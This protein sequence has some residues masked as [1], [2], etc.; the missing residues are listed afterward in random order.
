MV[1]YS[2]ACSGDSWWGGFYPEDDPVWYNQADLRCNSSSSRNWLVWRIT[3]L[4]FLLGL[5]IVLNGKVY[6]CS[7]RRNIPLYS[8]GS[9]RD[10]E[11]RTCLHYHNISFLHYPS[12]LHF[13]GL[14]V[15]TCV[16]ADRKVSWC[17]SSARRSYWKHSR[18]TCT[19]AGN[20]VKRN[21]LF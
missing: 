5:M 15:R 17:Y 20:D 9:K 16:T 18:N 4:Y 12:H 10:I 11:R 14:T 2:I 6:S 1:G 3:G 13:N 21:E 7:G 8:M 19:S